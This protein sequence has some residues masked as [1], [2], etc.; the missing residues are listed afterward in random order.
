MFFIVASLSTNWTHIAPRSF[1]I[2]IETEFS[3][4]E[5][6]YALEKLRQWHIMQPILHV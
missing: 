5:I 1:T 4:C 2:F 6:E 3:S